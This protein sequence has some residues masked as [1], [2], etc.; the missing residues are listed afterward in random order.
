MPARVAL[1]R[2]RYL[3]LHFVCVKFVVNNFNVWEYGS[4][5][6]IAKRLV[7][8]RAGLFLF[9]AASDNVDFFAI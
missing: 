6:S 8:Y 7:P 4:Q 5:A 3:N 9:P 2:C 1:V